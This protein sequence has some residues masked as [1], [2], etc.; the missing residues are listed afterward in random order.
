MIISSFR[1]YPFFIRFPPSYPMH[2]H[3]YLDCV[4][5]ID[6]NLVCCTVNEHMKITEHFYLPA[7]PIACRFLVWLLCARTHI[8]LCWDFIRNR[9]GYRKPQWGAASSAER[10]VLGL[11][12]A[13]SKRT[14][15]FG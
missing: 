13:V 15:G 2:S 5:G 12:G 7:A 4:R 9:N 3:P 11:P 1:F 8:Y 10:G 14:D 6:G